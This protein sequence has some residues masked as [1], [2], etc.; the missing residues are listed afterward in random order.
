MQV[1]LDGE[2]LEDVPPLPHLEDAAAGDLVRQRGPARSVAA[3]ADRARRPISPFSSGSRPEMAFSVVVF[4][5]PFAPRSA[6][7]R[8]SGTEQGEPL[9]HLDGV[10]VHDLQVVDGERGGRRRGVVGRLTS[11]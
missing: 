8:P 10:V 1:L 9:Q 3:V 7:M 5:A 11:R 4:P 2:L 6:T